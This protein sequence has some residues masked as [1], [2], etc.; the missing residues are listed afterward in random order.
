MR[1]TPGQ[2]LSAH[3]KRSCSLSLPWAQPTRS[4]FALKGILALKSVS[5]EKVGAASRPRYTPAR[6]LQTP[7]LTARSRGGRGMRAAVLRT[8]LPCSPLLLRPLRR[9]RGP[10]AADLPGRLSRG[11]RR[12]AWVGQVLGGSGSACRLPVR[13]GGAS[14]DIPNGSPLSG[15]LRTIGSDAPRRVKG[16]GRDRVGTLR[17]RRDAQAPRATESKRGE[18]GQGRK[19]GCG[20]WD[21]VHTVAPSVQRH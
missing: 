10:P 6:L 13:G 16:G 14:P 21:W 9:L 17:R 11:A 2:G 4:L 1:K 19:T 8:R 5:P 3:L 15:R 18:P 7:H 20:S 12:M